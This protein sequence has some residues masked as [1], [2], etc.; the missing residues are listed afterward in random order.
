MVAVFP[1][2]NVA[3]IGKTAGMEQMRQTA[4]RLTV[5]EELSTA[6]ATA[7][8]ALGAKIDVMA[9]KIVTTT[10]MKRTVLLRIARVSQDTVAMAGVS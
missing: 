10:R 1:W 4:P 3:T 2:I 7:C 5:E 9:T 6:E 8:V